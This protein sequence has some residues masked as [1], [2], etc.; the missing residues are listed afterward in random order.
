MPQRPNGAHLKLPAYGRELL[1]AR[2]RGVHPRLIWVLYGDNWRDRPNKP[3]EIRS[4]CVDEGYAPATFDWSVL[5]GVRVVIDWR[6]GDRICELVAEIA[7]E[8]APVHV[9]Y[10]NGMLNEFVRYGGR[11]EVDAATFL[12][13]ERHRL[14][15]L[16]T[17]LTEQDYLARESA[18]YRA[19]VADIY[20]KE[21][22]GHGRR[23]ESA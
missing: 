19:A 1:T 8:A 22:L 10:D 14:R 4:V 3:P 20:D 13:A 11:E 2:E 17:E 18:W 23:T 9:R 16:W 5:A 12:F 21:S 15:P 7:R 6:G